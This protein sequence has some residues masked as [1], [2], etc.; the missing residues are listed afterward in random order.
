MVVAA[1]QEAAV[2]G[3][4]RAKVSP[5]L[6]GEGKGGE[7]VAKVK[8]SS[9]S[10]GRS[11]RRVTEPAGE[12]EGS[13]PSAVGWE[14]RL[15]IAG[16]SPRSRRTIENLNRICGEYLPGECR[17]RVIDLLKNPEL[18]H[19]DQILAIPT[20]VKDFPE[21]VCIIIGD[22]S[23]LERVLEKLGFPAT[24]APPFPGGKDDHPE[25][26]GVRGKRNL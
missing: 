11:G 16:D 7:G 26:H 8:T 25:R 22:L 19:E 3:S 23:S 13:K 17:V 4:P 21:P 12:R 10:T 18:A 1:H 2:R 6:S 24:E 9:G 15:Y 5:S 20:L 14:F